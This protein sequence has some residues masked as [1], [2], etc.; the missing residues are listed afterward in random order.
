[1]GQRDLSWGWEMEN[2]DWRQNIGL[3]DQAWG[4][5]TKHGAERPSMGLGD[6]A[7]GWETKTW[8]SETEH[9][10][11][12]LW[13]LHPVFWYFGAHG[14]E[15]GPSENTSWEVGSSQRLHVMALSDLPFL[16]ACYKT[17]LPSLAALCSLVK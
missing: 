4:W 11:G 6:R 12:K 14:K 10:A 9:G 1:M 13:L 2:G 7:W 5:E 15:T 17:H 3:G 16:A 8:G